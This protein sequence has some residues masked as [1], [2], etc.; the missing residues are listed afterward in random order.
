MEIKGKIGMAGVLLSLLL[1]AASGMAVIT[2]AD[3]PSPPNLFNGNVAINGENAPLGT[4]INA[5]INGELKG[6]I[7]V[8][9]AGK[10]G[11]DVY[12]AVNGESSDEDADITFTVAGCNAG[13]TAKWNAY[14]APRELD[15]SVER[16]CGDVDQYCG[17]D[18]RDAAHLARHIAEIP[19]YEVLYGNGDVDG[20]VGLDVR[21]AAHLARYIAEIPGYESLNCN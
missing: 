15:L 14:A 5:Y 6:S 18:V 17:L 13:Q 4:V 19:G 20:K 8:D 12:L 11:D 7:T 1:L 21:D 10:Y 9:T 16:V 2:A 3:Q